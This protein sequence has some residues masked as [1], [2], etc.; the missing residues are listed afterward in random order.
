[1][2]K[3]TRGRTVTENSEIIEVFWQKSQFCC[4]KDSS[5]VLKRTRGRTVTE[6]SE[7]IEVFGKNHSS[8]VAKTVV[9]C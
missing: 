1:M 8:V 5:L 6:N 7:I 9:W 2:L 3:R 4:C